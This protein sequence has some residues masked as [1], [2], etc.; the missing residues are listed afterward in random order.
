MAHLHLHL[1]L[2]RTISVP[3]DRNNTAQFH[4]LA[5]SCGHNGR[6]VQL[7]GYRPWYV[8]GR[9]EFTQYHVAQYLGAVIVILVG[10]LHETESVD[11][12]N[13]ALAIGTQQIE[14][15]DRLLEGQTYLARYELLGVIEYDR[16]AYL[17]ALAIALHLAVQGGTLAS[18]RV[19]I[20][21]PHCVDLDVG[22]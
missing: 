15:A 13:V 17:L 22:A 5:E 18:L 21:R 16:V 4:H 2:G 9:R 19:G 12:A 7:E 3:D 8:Q 20:V 6:I 10:V 1:L 11:I 14:A